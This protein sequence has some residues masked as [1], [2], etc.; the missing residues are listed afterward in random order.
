MR[1]KPILI[2]KTG[3]PD[4]LEIAEKALKEKGIPFFK[5]QES[6][7]GIRLAMTYQPF[8]GSGNRFSIFVPRKAVKDARSVLSV[9]EIGTCSSACGLWMYGRITLWFLFI[10]IALMMARHLY[11][12]FF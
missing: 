6:S 8:M 3:K 2:L 5:Q 11:E 12:P 10:A 7:N 4:E 1:R 9:L